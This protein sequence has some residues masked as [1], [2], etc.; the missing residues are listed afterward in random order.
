MSEILGVTRVYH[1]ARRI[2]R[3][4]E[5]KLKY[6]DKNSVTVV[7]IIFNENKCVEF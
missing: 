2:C 7:S 1:T 3:Q 6:F 4:F 5:R